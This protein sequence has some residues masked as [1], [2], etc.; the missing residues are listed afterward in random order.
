[1]LDLRKTANLV[2]PTNLV[3]SLVFGFQKECTH[4]CE[5]KY[6]PLQTLLRWLLLECILNST[7]ES[8]SII[9]DC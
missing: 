6:L 5:E 1:M 9:K 2:T 4:H 8:V 7:Y 3:D